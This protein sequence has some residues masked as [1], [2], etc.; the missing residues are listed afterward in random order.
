MKH[1]LSDEA[2]LDW[3]ERQPING[4]YEYLSNSDCAYARYL[5]WVG[6]SFRSIGGHDWKDLSGKNHLL[7]KGVRYALSGGRTLTFG[8]AAERLRH[9]LSQ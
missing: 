5:K 1:P 4:E 7:S 2:F 8:S 6:I 9:A 3:L